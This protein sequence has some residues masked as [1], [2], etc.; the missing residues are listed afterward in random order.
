MA[1]EATVDLTPDS[2]GVSATL[3]ATASASDADGGTVTLT[4]VWTLNGVIVKTTAGTSA[5]SDELDLTSLDTQVQAGDE[6]AV[7]VTPNDGVLDGE[8][9]F[10]SVIIIEG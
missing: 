4:Y 5:L 10:D 3:T 2:P 8:T 9:K 1:P 6:V 7:A